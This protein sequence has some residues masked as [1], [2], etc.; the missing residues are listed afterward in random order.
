MEGGDGGI[1]DFSI[2]RYARIIGETR[3]YLGCS[4]SMKMMM[5]LDD[6]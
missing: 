5:G 1:D 6:T 3:S 2:E 4:G